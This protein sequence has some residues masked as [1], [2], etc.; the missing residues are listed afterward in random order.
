[1]IDS[2]ISVGQRLRFHAL[3]RIHHQQRAL[4]RSQRARDFVAEV[5]VSRRIDQVELVGLAV[6][7][8]VHHA[9]RVGFDG[10]APLALQVHRIQDLRLHFTTR[11]RARQFQQ[12]VAQRRLAMV[13][14]GNNG[15]IS[16][17]FYV[18]QGWVI[19]AANTTKMSD[20]SMA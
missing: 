4:A 3:A 11:H 18:H 7:C 13:D 20:V 14:M 2:E 9:D 5:H 8:L 1:M 19:T 6:A 12:T 15:E 17:V 16:K 10:D